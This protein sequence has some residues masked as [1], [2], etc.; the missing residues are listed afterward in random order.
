VAGS[1]HTDGQARPLNGSYA[2]HA[3]RYGKPY[4]KVRPAPLSFQRKDAMISSYAH[5]NKKPVTKLLALF[6][7]ALTVPIWGGALA[8]VIGGGFY[9]LATQPVLFLVIGGGLLLAAAMKG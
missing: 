5:S 1:G 8:A 3:G 6:L 9:L 7:T 2:H 4:L